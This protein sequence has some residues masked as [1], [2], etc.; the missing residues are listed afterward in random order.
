MLAPAD[1]R[2]GL[3]LLLLD[4]LWGTIRRR[5]ET[6]RVLHAFGPFRFV[7]AAGVSVV[8]PFTAVRQPPAHYS[9]AGGCRAV[10]LC[11]VAVGRE[12]QCS[13]IFCRGCCWLW[14]WAT[15][16]RRWLAFKGGSMLL[17]FTSAAC[18]ACVRYAVLFV[19][20]TPVVL[21]LAVWVSPVAPRFG[22]GC[23]AGWT[24]IAL[25]GLRRGYC[26]CGWKA[27]PPAGWD[28]L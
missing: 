19:Y 8:L 5:G 15:S 2:V 18:G 14:C 22:S 20:R 7:G 4:K 9:T 26:N 24:P 27:L 12:K 3:S 21:V 6:N 13:V 16:E 28:A 11:A 25:Q 1:L 23:G 10:E 17:A